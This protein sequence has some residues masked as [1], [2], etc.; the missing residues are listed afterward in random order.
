M[1]AI[2]PKCH[3][4]CIDVNNYGKKT[5]AFIGAVF[6]ALSGSVSVWRGAE[7]GAVGGAILGPA[8]VIIG[9]IA[10][11]V[12]GGLIGGTA[13][14]AT[15]VKLGEYL[16][17]HLFDNYRCLECGHKFSTALTSPE[18]DHADVGTNSHLH[19]QEYPS[20]FGPVS[21]RNQENEQG[22]Y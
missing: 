19:Q 11:S 17:T 9:A 18:N 14:A 16:D 20:G 8:G 4:T 6:G 13:G 1:T 15:G 3:S 7:I 21:H 2:C 22:F 5:G 10:G 12:L